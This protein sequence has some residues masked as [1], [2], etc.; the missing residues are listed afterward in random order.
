M[1]LIVGTCGTMSM[2]AVII[3]ENFTLNICMLGNCSC[4]CCGLLTFFQNYSFSEKNIS[5]TLS[6]CQRF[7]IHFR[8]NVHVCGYLMS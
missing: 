4:F 8:I 2:L 6:E 5:E 7:W 1:R 3:L